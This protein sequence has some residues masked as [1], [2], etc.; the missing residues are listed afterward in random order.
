MD[1]SSADSV[2]NPSTHRVSGSYNK[3]T[4]LSSQQNSS[5][6]SSVNLT[7]VN[8]LADGARLSQPDVRPDAV[9]RAKQLLDDPNW[10]SDKNLISLSAKIIRTEDFS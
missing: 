3:L 7:D 6:E 2:N 8:A 5:P 1:L 9:A 10:L 4:G